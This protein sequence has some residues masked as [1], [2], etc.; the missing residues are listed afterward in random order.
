MAPQRCDDKLA[1]LIVRLHD[2]DEKWG[3][4]KIAKHVKMSKDGVWK[5]RNREKHPKP[6]KTGGK[7]RSTDGRTD[8]K[9]ARKS[10]EEPHLTAP[11]IREELG[12]NDISL[13][14]VQRRLEELYLD[15]TQ[16]TWISPKNVKERIKFAK[17]HQEWTVDDWKRVLWSDESKFN[18]VGM[19]PKAM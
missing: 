9:I 18:F 11:E 3:F 13:R 5:I 15:V 19:M 17:K 6:I 4:G 7:R 14:T 2:T 1:K 12:L 8:R 16:Q 10:K